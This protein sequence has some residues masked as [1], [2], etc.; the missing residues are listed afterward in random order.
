MIPLVFVGFKAKS[1]HDGLKSVGGCL[2]FHYVIYLSGSFW[3]Y[4][5]LLIFLSF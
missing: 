5:L 2:L 4:F 3:F 1:L